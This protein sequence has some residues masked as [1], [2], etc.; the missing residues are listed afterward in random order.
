MMDEYWNWPFKIWQSSADVLGRQWLASQCRLLRQHLDELALAPRVPHD[1]QRDQ[2]EVAGRHAELLSPIGSETQRYILYLHGGGFALGSLDTH[3]ELAALLARE[4][5]AHVLLLDYRLAPEHP[6]PAGL[7]DARAA[8]HWLHDTGVSPE[9]L[10]L[11]GDSAGGALVLGLLQHL[12][13]AHLPQPA[14]AVMMSPWV[15]LT[16]SALSIDY[17]APTDLVIQRPQLKAFAELYA[18]RRPLNDPGISPLFGDLSQLPP[19]L[20]QVSQHESLRDDAVRLKRG[21]QQAGGE[22]ELEEVPWMPHVWQLMS[23]WWPQAAASLRQAGRFV[24][25]HSE[26]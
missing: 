3:R 23:S 9:R 24:R 22:V 8:W 11:A 7:E 5:Q 2:L 15:D 19:M 12:R 1:I 16:C 13:D 6:W 14:A 20:L 25:Q 21:L 17:N 4:A 10:V 18:G 26:A